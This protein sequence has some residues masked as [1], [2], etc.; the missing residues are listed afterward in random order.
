MLIGEF[1]VRA[2]MILGTAEDETAMLGATTWLWMHSPLHQNA[3]LI[4][5]SDLLLPVLKAQ[6]YILVSHAARP[7]FYL[8]FAFFDEQ[9]EWHY[10]NDHYDGDRNVPLNGGDRLWFLD[11]IAPFGHSRDMANL[12]R[13]EIFPYQ[14]LRALYHKGAARGAQVIRFRGEGVSHEQAAQWLRAHPLARPLPERGFAR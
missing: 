12:L 4:A 14:C 1:D 10:L 5:L 7:I 9:T 3:P 8:S 13:R 2:P 6:Q 11:W